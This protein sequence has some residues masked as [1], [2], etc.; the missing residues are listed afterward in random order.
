MKTADE[1]NLSRWLAVR[2]RVFEIVE[3]GRERDTLRHIFDNFIIS[4]ILLNVIAFAAETV[5]SLHKKWH[6]E[7]FT[8]ELFSVAVFTFEY[9]VRVWASVE[10]PFLKRMSP[11]KARLKFSLRPFLIIDLLAILPFYLSFLH[12][13]FDLRVLRM[14]RIIRFLKLAR[15]SPALHTLIKVI[16]NERRALVGALILTLTMLLFASTGIYFIEK[17]IEGTPFSSVP[18]A[19]WWAMATLT[20]VGYGDIT[21]ES[22]LGKIFGSVVMLMG[23]GLFA[24]PIAIISTGFAQ[25][26]SRRDFVVTWSLLS[27][28]PLFSQLNAKSIAELMNFLQAHTYPPHWEVIRAK[29]A[30]TS[31][32]FIASGEVIIERSDVTVTLHAGDFFGEIA[33]IE[34]EPYEYS[35]TTLTSTKVLELTRDDYMRLCRAQPEVCDHI[36][37]VAVARQFARERGQADPSGI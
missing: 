33:M 15:Y 11:W 27:R 32:F 12:P 30:G 9:I 23:L 16:S 8:F 26:S 14:F 24:L 37:A 25:E 29:E 10:V 36:G 5:P 22:P 4:L 1:K 31:M 19:A 6:K 2:K 35:Y 13:V 28:I 21:P 3:S 17:D 18:A 7:F 20:T 34:Q